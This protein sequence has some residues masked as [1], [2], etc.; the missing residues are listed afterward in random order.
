MTHTGGHTHPHL[1]T[2]LYN[3]MELEVEHPRPPVN[4]HTCIQSREERIRTV[5]IQV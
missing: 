3:A 4:M 1:D 2:T 5:R